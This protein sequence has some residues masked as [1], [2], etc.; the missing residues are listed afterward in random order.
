MPNT[1][2][3]YTWFKHLILSNC[4]TYHVTPR[5]LS[6]QAGRSQCAKEVKSSVQDPGTIPKASECPV[7]VKSPFSSELCVKTQ[8]SQSQTGLGLN[9]LH[10]SQTNSWVLTGWVRQCWWCRFPAALRTGQCMRPGATSGHVT[11]SRPQTA[12]CISAQP[13]QKSH[14]ALSVCPSLVPGWMAVRRDVNT[15]VSEGGK[16]QEVNIIIYYKARFIKIFV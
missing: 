3:L 15:L 11:G 2:N 7:V 13:L 6:F 4:N 10:Q 8:T 1:Y 5:D 16:N 12:H 9:K 14:P